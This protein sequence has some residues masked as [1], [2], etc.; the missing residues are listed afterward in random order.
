MSFMNIVKILLVTISMAPV[1]FLRRMYW[2][3]RYW[4][5]PDETMGE[6][7][8][9]FRTF[10]AVTP[11]YSKVRSREAQSGGGI[12]LQ[13]ITIDGYI[14]VIKKILIDEHC[15]F[16]SKKNMDNVMEKLK[17][18]NK[19]Y[20]HTC[21]CASAMEWHMRFW[22]IRVKIARP[23]KPE[24]LPREN[25]SEMDVSQLFKACK[26]TRDKAIL[27]VC[28]YA[29]PRTSEITKLKTSEFEG[30]GL[31]LFI[32]NGKYSRDRRTCI[33]EEAAEAIQEWITMSKKSLM[34]CFSPRAQ[35][36]CAKQ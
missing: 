24:R 21:N 13:T 32:N 28:A 36:V 15:V 12:S 14:K 19:S 3:Y 17:R 11:S 1:N 6:V 34:T 26:T 16:L 30:D 5:R 27:S 33:N 22:G 31:S 2:Q 18:E 25:L 29:G 7:L 8:G 20:T 9:R 4:K 35:E 10:L 23:R